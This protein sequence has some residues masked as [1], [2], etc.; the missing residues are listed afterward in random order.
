[1][2]T[3][4]EARARLESLGFSCSEPSAA[5]RRKLRIIPLGHV[6]I[7]E[8]DLEGKPLVTKSGQRM[9]AFRFQNPGSGHG[10]IEIPIDPT[11]EDLAFLAEHLPIDTETALREFKRTP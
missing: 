6:D 5:E 9:R 3:K 2:K 11:P 10:T 1:M 4:K 8:T 7:I